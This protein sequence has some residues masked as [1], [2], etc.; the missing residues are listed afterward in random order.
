MPFFTTDSC[1][2]QRALEIGAE[3]LVMAKDGVDGV[4]SGDPKTDTNATKFEKLTASEALEQGLAV[5]DG[6]ALALARDNKLPIKVVAIADIAR[7]LEDGVGTDVIA[8]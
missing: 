3:V 1:A 2:V 7:A 6:S 5:A 4:Y 8:E